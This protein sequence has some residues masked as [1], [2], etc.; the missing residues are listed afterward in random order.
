MKFTTGEII[1]AATGILCCPVERLYAIYN[2]MTGDN[3]FTHQLPRAFKVCQSH[4][5]TQCPW[6]KELKSSECTEETWRDFI[7]DAEKIYGLEH[8]LTKLPDGIWNVKDPIQE[9]VEIMGKD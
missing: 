5:Q 2:F 4:I 6:V 1:S 9:A 7:K 3:L 8:E